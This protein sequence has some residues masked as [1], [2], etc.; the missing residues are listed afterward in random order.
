MGNSPWH[1]PHSLVKG[2][3]VAFPIISQRGVVTSSPGRISVMSSGLIHH[4]RSKGLAYC[5]WT[6]PPSSYIN[7]QPSQIR[8]GN[9]FRTFSPLLPPCSHFWSGPLVVWQLHRNSLSLDLP[10]AHI[11][12]K[13]SHMALFFHDWL[14][15]FNIVIFKGRTLPNLYGSSRLFLPSSSLVCISSPRGCEGKPHNFGHISSVANHFLNIISSA[16]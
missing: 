6:L 4:L 1:R 11:S 12:Y 15:W 14:L 16:A 8:T 5:P 9:N 7:S 10:A 13:G 3:L 2:H